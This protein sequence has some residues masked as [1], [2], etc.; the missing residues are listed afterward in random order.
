M[1]SKIFI[2][3]VPNGLAHQR[4]AN[5]HKQALVEIRPNPRIEVMD[6]LDHC[7]GGSAPIASRMRPTL[8]TSLAFGVGSKASS[9]R[10]DRPGLVGFLQTGT[11]VVAVSSCA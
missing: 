6:T 9:T 8:G 10:I 11:T 1:N 3:I 5:P 4:I 2:L 7:P